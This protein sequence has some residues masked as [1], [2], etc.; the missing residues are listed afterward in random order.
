MLKPNFVIHREDEIRAIRKAAHA[1]ATV[2]EKLIQLVRP[3]MTTKNLDD[4]AGSLIASTGGT[5][6]FLGYRGFPG[7]ICI[8]LNEEVVHGIGSNQRILN[9]GDLV[10]L[11]IGV[12]LDGGVGDTAKSFCLGRI[13]APDESM[14]LENTELALMEGIKEAKAGNYVGDISAA[15]EKVAKKAGL[16]VVREYVGHGCGTLLHE[17][18]EVPNFVT[19]NRGPRL[20]PGMVLAIEPMFNLGTHKVIT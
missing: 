4:L 9:E 15:V 8:S 18:P 13:P 1:A 14:L 7:Q 19:G 20:V 6:A 10:S 5:S 16:G 2:R 12:K 17:P 11:D 3:G